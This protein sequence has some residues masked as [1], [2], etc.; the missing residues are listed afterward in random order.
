MLH[1]SL[2]PTIRKHF[3]RNGLY[4]LKSKSILIIF[5]LEILIAK[6]PNNA[7]LC[8]YGRLVRGCSIEMVL[9]LEME[10][11]LF[12]YLS[13]DNSAKVCTEHPVP[14]KVVVT[15]LEGGSFIPSAM[16]ILQLVESIQSKCRNGLHA[17]REQVLKCSVCLH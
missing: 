1:A 7:E 8:D 2:I 6:L 13:F 11:G 17:H 9:V 10:E 16:Q 3:L 4:G 5:E 12:G 14:G 15:T